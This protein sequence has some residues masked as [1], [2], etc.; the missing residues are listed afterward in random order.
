LRPGWVLIENHVSLISAGTERAKLELKSMNLLQKARARPDLVQKVVDR[1]RVEGI[2]NTVSVARE[3]LAE[4]DPLGYSSAGVVLSVG[5]GVEGLAP[6]TRVACGGAGWANH[7]EI[8]SVPKRL[9]ATVPAHVRLE[10]AA[11]AT[12]GAIALHAVRQSEASIGERVGV[13]GLGL[14]GQLALRILLAAGCD[15]VG[16]DLDPVAIEVARA[17]GATG[18]QR[19]DAGM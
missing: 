18:V 6:G 10:D 16:I 3:R 8:V 4:L 9:V 12:V 17:A 14:V 2:R 13:I 5:T 11:Y 19:N 7:A 15:V 1:A